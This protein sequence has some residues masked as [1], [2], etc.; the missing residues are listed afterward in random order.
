MEKKK[1]LKEGSQKNMR[2][3]L[4][5]IKLPAISTLHYRLSKLDEKLLEEAILKISQEVGKKT[6]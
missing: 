2:I 1:S 5:K 3:Y 4:L 6:R